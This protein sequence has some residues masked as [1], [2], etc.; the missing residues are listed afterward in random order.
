MDLRR[1]GEEEVVGV[2]M[3]GGRYMVYSYNLLVSFGL[4]RS[5]QAQKEIRA[6]LS[7]MGD[8]RPIV[9]RTIAQGIAGV[10]TKLDS[11]DVICK[12]YKLYGENP[13][14]FCYTSKWVPVDRW[15]SSDLDSMSS[16]VASLKG[17]IGED[18]RWMMAVE[19]RRYTRY[20]K[21]DII[22]RLAGHIAGRVSQPSKP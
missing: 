4:G 9:K 20:H 12:L 6:T 19:K 21:I 13:A 3:G 10:E 7:G 14:I 2:Y 18:E 8:S 1:V 16:L 5:Y 15:T 17:K 22:S 11:R